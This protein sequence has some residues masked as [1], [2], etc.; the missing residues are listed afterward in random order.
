MKTFAERLRSA[1]KSQHRLSQ[2]ELARRL[3][4]SKSYLNE[5]EKGAKVNPSDELLW[6]IA[7]ELLVRPEWLRSGDGEM[8]QFEASGV[9]MRL[10]ADKRVME[11]K[12]HT[13]EAASLA[14]RVFASTLPPNEVAQKVGSILI[15]DQADLPA[16]IE[17]A[18]QVLLVL[19][20]RLGGSTKS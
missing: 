7:S 1:R 6:K 5:L 12:T 2:A 10:D 18:L 4:L 14:L 17:F 19:R 3:G 15:S 20:D 13:P 16:R 8:R 11:V 9:T